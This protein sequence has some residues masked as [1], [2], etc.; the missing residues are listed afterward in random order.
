MGKNVDWVLPFRDVNGKV[1]FMSPL[2][3]L[4]KVPS[5]CRTGYTARQDLKLKGCWCQSSIKFLE[6]KIRKGE[7]LEMPWLDY[8][9]MFA[10]FPLHE[11]RHRAY[12]CYKLG[13]KKIPVY[14][15]R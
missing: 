5:P 8:T 12:V 14:V 13:I 9:H 6:R 3:F 1:V 7:S 2:T 10:G 11:G 15:V 4:S